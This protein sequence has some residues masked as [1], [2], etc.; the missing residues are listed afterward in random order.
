MYSLI[1]GQQSMGR[2]Q[3]ITYE[4]SHCQINFDTNAIRNIFSILA[5][6]LLQGA[7]SFHH[8][9]ESVCSNALQHKIKDYH[10]GKF[11]GDLPS[12]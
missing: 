10:G 6:S 5:V 2:V 4:V 11:V 7:M 12:N 9:L 3:L 8:F 1:I